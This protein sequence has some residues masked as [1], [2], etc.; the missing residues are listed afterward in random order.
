MVFVIGNSLTR[1]S[2]WHWILLFLTVNSF[3]TFAQHVIMI[4]SFL[5]VICSLNE[6]VTSATRISDHTG[7]LVTSV[8]V[9]GV[10]VAVRR[11]FLHYCNADQQAR[12]AFSL[13]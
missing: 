12:N 1:V 2:W 13:S 11:F 3:Q 5:N 6:P 9:L 8:S 4:F 10:M 7:E